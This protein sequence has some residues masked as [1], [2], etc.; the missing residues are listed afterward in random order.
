MRCL[1]IHLH[2]LSA[3]HVRICGAALATLILIPPQKRLQAFQ[4]F[5]CP[6]ELGYFVGRPPPKEF[7]ENTKMLPRISTSIM[8]RFTND[9]Y[10]EPVEF[11][12]YFGGCSK[13]P[14]KRRPKTPIKTRVI[15]LPGIYTLHDHTSW[16][17]LSQREDGC[18]TH[19]STGSGI[20]ASSWCVLRKFRGNM[21][22]SPK[23]W[24]TP[25]N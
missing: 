1:Q 14:S 2:R 15:W 22:R 18:A 21:Q 25:W 7:L 8:K 4:W 9:M 13:T 19:T 12:L 10:L 6:L 17:W 11:V 24:Y 3:L 23:V 16:R 20:S 5:V